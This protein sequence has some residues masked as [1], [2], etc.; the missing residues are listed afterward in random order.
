[1]HGWRASYAVVRVTGGLIRKRALVPVHW[2]GPISWCGCAIHAELPRHAIV[3]A[4][5]YRPGRPPDAD[6]EDRL[7]RWYGSPIPA[8]AATRRALGGRARGPGMV[9]R[10]WNDPGASA[11]RKA[12]EE[13][14][15]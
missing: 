1:V 13:P 9:S 6:Y 12:F 10:A 4:P 8:D 5:D 14:A 7:R 3:R 15:R 2:L 11:D